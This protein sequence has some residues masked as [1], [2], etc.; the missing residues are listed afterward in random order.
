MIIDILYLL[1]AAI[2]QYVNDV[3]TTEARSLLHGLILEGHVGY[4]SIEFKSDCLEV[5]EV[6]K[7][8]NSIGPAATIFEECSFLSRNFNFI[9]FNHCPREVNSC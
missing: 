1:V 2:L 5:V 7:Q 9:L 8:G 6:M 4:S 3:V